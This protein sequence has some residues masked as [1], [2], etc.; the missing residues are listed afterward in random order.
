MENSVYSTATSFSRKVQV[1]KMH[2]KSNT[3]FERSGIGRISRHH[4]FALEKGFN[5]HGHSHVIILEEDLLVAP[6]FFR[7]MARSAWL[8]DDDPTLWCVSAWNDNGDR[9]IAWDESRLYRTDYFAGLGWMI[10]K[11]EWDRLRGHWPNVPSTGWD[12]WMRLSTTNQGRECIVPEVSRTRHIGEHGVN[13]HGNN[14]YVK[15][16]FSSGNSELGDLKYLLNDT[17]EKSV[18]KAV[19]EAY[20]SHRVTFYTLEE[21]RTIA[22]QNSLW[23]NQP[24]GTHRGIILVHMRDGSMKVIADRRKAWEYIRLEDQKKPNPK[25]IAIKSRIGVSC[26]DACRRQGK[27]CD[28]AEIQFLN[29]CESLLK[30]FACEAGCGHQMGREIPSYV[31]NPRE[32]TY[33]QCLVSDEV[34]STCS[35]KHAVTERLCACV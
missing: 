8:L 33:Q 16:A 21:F 23:Q 26:T 4:E 12:H 11:Q 24:R 14:A 10:K 6:D 27:T 13:V 25:S 32:R 9:A 3:P 1:L 7:L 2:P 29:N 31:V 30:M 15:W 35:A 34:V 22:L 20:E 17:Y 19:E 28:A 18:R 5:T